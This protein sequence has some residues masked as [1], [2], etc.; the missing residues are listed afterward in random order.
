MKKL[1]IFETPKKNE[2]S[3]KTD[4]TGKKFEKEYP[5]IL[6]KDIQNNSFIEKNPQG[7]SIMNLKDEKNI[8]EIQCSYCKTLCYFSHVQCQ[9][10]KLAFCLKHLSQVKQKSFNMIILVKFLIL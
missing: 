7:I 5:L 4:Y 1:K 3:K 6:I 8:I 10:H 2:K 9:I